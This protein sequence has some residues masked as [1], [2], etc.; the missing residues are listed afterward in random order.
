MFAH[1]W[2]QHR[3]VF[4]A[5]ENQEGLYVFF[6]TVCDAYSLIPDDNYTVPTEAEGIEIEE[7]HRGQHGEQDVQLEQQKAFDMNRN[8]PVTPQAGN[9]DDITSALGAPAAT[10]RRHKHTPSTGS[11]VMSI[12]EGDEET[13]ETEETGRS[14]HPLEES[15]VPN[16]ESAPKE[17]PTSGEQNLIPAA[18]SDL[19]QDIHLDT[20]ELEKPESEQQD[21]T[22][23][24]E[25]PQVEQQ[26][27]KPVAKEEDREVPSLEK[28]EGEDEEK[29]KVKD[30]KVEDPS[31]LETKEPAVADGSTAP[32]DELKSEDKTG[33]CEDKTGEASIE[34][35]N[36][37]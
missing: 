24:S 30:K 25:E 1:A 37:M 22:P 19:L 20:K 10:A 14:E 5:I 11:F 18:A 31:P 4:W 7:E 23:I 29:E 34:A 28:N 33:K 32:N 12:A 15:L 9:P 16:L 8:S 17:Q 27:N 2:F 21:S 13:E 35:P 3:E 26:G 6:K 36:V